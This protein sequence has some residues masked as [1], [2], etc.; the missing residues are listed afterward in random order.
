[1]SGSRI[2]RFEKTERSTLKRLPPI[3]FELCDW[4]YGVRA[5]DDYHVEHARSFLYSVPSELRG[6][7]VDLRYRIDARGHAS[8][9]ARC[10]IGTMRRHSPDVA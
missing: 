2:E 7:R 4:R 10:R 6:Q 9:P 3:P 1:M 5:G 8:R